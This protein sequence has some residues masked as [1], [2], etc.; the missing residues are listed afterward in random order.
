MPTAWFCSAHVGAFAGAF[1][2]IRGQLATASSAPLRGSITI[3]DAAF[4]RKFAPT[5]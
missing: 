1:E 2:S 3:A 4:G 5:P